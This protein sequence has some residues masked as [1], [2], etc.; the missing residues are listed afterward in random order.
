MSDRVLVFSCRPA[1][2]KAE[3]SIS[4]AGDTPLHRRNAPEF[5]DYF[6]MI[7]KEIDH[8]DN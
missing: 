2:L 8:D 5:K 1:R 6:D 3:H 7:W 4:V